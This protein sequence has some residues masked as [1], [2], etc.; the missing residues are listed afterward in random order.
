MGRQTAAT[1]LAAKREGRK[2]SMVTAYDYCTARMVD[3]AGI[4]GIL[5]G[6]SLGMTMLG[7]ESTLPVTMEDMAHHTAAVARGAQNAL[8]IAD[9]PYLSYQVST[10]EAVRNAGRLVQEA[11]A[12]AVKLE[13]GA[14]FV[15]EVRAITRAS[16]PV[17]GH[18][19]LTPQS[20]NRLGGYKAQG[21]SAAEAQ[22]ILDDAR[23]LEEAGA[24]AVV[25]ECVPAPLAQI[26]TEAL[27]I[28]TIGIGSGANCDG[29]VLVCQD[30]LG[31][32]EG[33]Q[34]RF[35]RRFAEV[36]K[37]MKEA[38]KAYREAVSD[39]SFPGEEHTYKAEPGA[40]D[41]IR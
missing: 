2:I 11:G 13:G 8:V 9:M 35:V 33:A 15:G 41:A 3:E 18:L 22:R 4:D 34:P 26:V 7:H 38:F 21:K 10:P 27:S 28:P 32:Y 16:I 14:D 6:D 30:L 36:G 25:L 37:Q 39:G 17:M 29:Q 1:F 31:M 24:F 12:A 40:Y 5:V 19:G 20:V 23:A